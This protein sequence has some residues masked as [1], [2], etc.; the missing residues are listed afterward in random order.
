[1]SLIDSERLTTVSRPVKTT[2]LPSDA[3]VLSLAS[4]SSQYAASSSA[5]VNVIQLYDK[6]NFSPNGQLAGHGEAITGMRAVPKFAGNTRETLISCGKD[7]LVK[8]WDER[9]GSVGLQSQSV[10]AL[11]LS[12]WL[13]SSEGHA[14]F[15]E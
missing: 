12:N 14:F 2:K 6:T 13:N 1:M 11:V 10:R 9:T 15:A 4:L 5:P 8:V 7:A 3:Y